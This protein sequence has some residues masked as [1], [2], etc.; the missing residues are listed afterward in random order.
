MREVLNNIVIYDGISNIW[1]DDS[2]SIS[3]IKV[4]YFI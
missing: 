2:I 3:N 1:V 4:T